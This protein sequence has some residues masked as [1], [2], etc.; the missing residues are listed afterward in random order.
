MSNLGEVE[1]SR[2]EGVILNNPSSSKKPTQSSQYK[3]FCFTFNNYDRDE[4]TILQKVF[5]TLCFMYAFQEET[6]EQGTPH[7]QGV[8][9][10]HKRARYSE[11]GLSKKIHWECT[12]D[13]KA[14]YLYCTKT[15]SR[16][17]QVF[18]KN[19]D[20]PYI[21]H[22]ETFYD[23]EKDINTLL[24]AEPSDRTIHWFWEPDGCAGKTTY[25]KYVFTHYE[26][27]VILSGKGADMKNGV[28]EYHK[29]NGRLPR[30]ILINI[31][32]CVG[33]DFLSYTG[34]E[35]VKDMF[36]FS[37]KYEGGMVC[38]KVHTYSASLMKNLT[39]VGCQV[40]DLS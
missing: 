3:H 2:D 4:I 15:Q 12:K 8:I 35:E 37:G 9:S 39:I 30:I 13:V 33:S 21:Q 14:S 19:Y 1:T 16:T 34:I 27:C 24:D 28:V 17:G 40:I 32:K 38:G 36:F 5:D 6:G 10:L 25:Q 7:L 29:K 20:L 31:P 11:F 18:T 26:Q 23:W 22:I